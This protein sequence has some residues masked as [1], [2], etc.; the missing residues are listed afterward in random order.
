[1]KM[2][3]ISRVKQKKN[4]TLVRILLLCKYNKEFVCLGC[5]QNTLKL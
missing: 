2:N 5:Y 1:M 3:I 4:G